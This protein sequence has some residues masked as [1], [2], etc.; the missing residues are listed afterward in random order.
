VPF[1][2]STPRP[3][4]IIAILIAFI[5]GTTF[6]EFAHAWTAQKLGD[7]TAERQGRVTLNPISHFDPVGFI[8][9][10]LIA[11]GGFGIGWGKPVPINAA[12]LRGRQRGFVLAIL[13]GPL[14]NVLLALIFAAPIRLGA[15][16]LPDFPNQL[17]S[18]MILI[19]MLLAA[20]NLI[21]IPPLDGFRILSGILPR[22]WQPFLAPLEQYGVFVLLILIF[23]GGFGMSILIPM[24]QPVFQALQRLVLG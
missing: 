15:P 17:V 9:M 22:F 7:D 2:F 8:G 14:S 23:F 5:V 12:K 19:N 21:P 18:Q 20:F 3:E 1:G 4:I 16:P 13:A 10:L 24:Y 11:I 6:H